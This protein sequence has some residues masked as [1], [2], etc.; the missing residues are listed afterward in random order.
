MSAGCLTRKANLGNSLP[1][2]HPLA[3]S[4]QIFTIVRIERLGA[5]SMLNHHIISITA[6]P[7]TS[8]TNDNRTIGGGKDRRAVISRQVHATAAETV[9]PLRTTTTGNWPQVITDISWRGT[10]TGVSVG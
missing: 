2:D 6:V 1:L 7:A 9:R 10:G 8:A 4:Y 5:I 3:D